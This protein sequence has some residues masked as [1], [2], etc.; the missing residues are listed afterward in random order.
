M[1]RVN[2]ILGFDRPSYNKEALN[3]AAAQPSGE[4]YNNPRLYSREGRS[5]DLR[6]TYN[7]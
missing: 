2:N 6:L 1:A 5:I 7:F 4:V 3:P